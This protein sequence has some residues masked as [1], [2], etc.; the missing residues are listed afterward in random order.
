MHLAAGRAFGE[1]G[2]GPWTCRTV[3]P[4]TLLLC[5]SLPLREF[6]QVHAGGKISKERSFHGCE[7][8]RLSFF[9]C[10]PLQ[11][12]VH[13]SGPVSTQLLFFS[14]KSIADSGIQGSRALV[15]L[16]WSL[17]LPSCC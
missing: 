13:G 10:H 8:N 4:L 14:G 1:V 9:P 5:R 17:C 2:P 12:P 6:A 16:I 3:P 11:P 15:R 7:V